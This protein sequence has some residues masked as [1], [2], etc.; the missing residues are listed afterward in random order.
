MTGPATSR[1]AAFV[2]SRAFMRWWSIFSVTASTTTI[3]SSTTRPM[4]STIAN[5]VSVLI[6]NPSP[7]KA[8]NVPISETGTASIGISVARQLSRKMKTTSSTRMTATTSVT[9][10]SC[11][12]SDT[13]SVVLNGTV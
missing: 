4:A 3:A 9:M 7:T 11:S 8:E 6:E 2:A 13:N 1:I 10:T 12:D 5:K